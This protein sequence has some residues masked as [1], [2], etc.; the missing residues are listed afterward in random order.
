MA[1]R[2]WTIYSNDYGHED[3][4]RAAVVNELAAFENI[5]HRIGLALTSAPIR[6]RVGSS[7]HTVGWAFRTD[8]V[9]TARE[10]PAPANV[11]PLPVE[12]EPEPEVAA[13]APAEGAAY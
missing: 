10:T 12:P 8:T 7:F 3:E 1:K 4:F 11:V 9:P 13:E 5:G 2:T 6:E